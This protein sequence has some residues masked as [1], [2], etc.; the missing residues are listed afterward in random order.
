MVPLGQA[1]R[2]RGNIIKIIGL[3]YTLGAASPLAMP[4]YR[5]LRDYHDTPA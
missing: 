3:D 4:T 2:N 1:R 5:Q